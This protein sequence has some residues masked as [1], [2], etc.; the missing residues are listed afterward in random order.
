M[1]RYTLKILQHSIPPENVRKPRF[2]DV[3]RGYRMLQDFESVSDHLGTLCINGFTCSVTCFAQVKY[4]IMLNFR[5]FVHSIF[6]LTVF[7]A[8]LDK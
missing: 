4:L 1:V 5:A 2:S 3:F 7:L 8:V 6:P